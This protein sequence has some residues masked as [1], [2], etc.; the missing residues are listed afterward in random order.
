[1]G[2]VFIGRDG[3]Y[4]YLRIFYLVG[5]G[6]GGRVEVGFIVIEVEGFF[7]GV[8]Y[9]GDVVVVAYREF[10]FYVDAVGVAASDEFGS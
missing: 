5:E 1:M 3:V 6:F 10:Y 7:V 9:V 2:E 4:F 8:G